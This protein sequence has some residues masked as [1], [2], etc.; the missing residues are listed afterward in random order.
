[1]LQTASRPVEL[2]LFDEDTWNI[3]QY[4]VYGL[5]FSGQYVRF[6]LTQNGSTL[7]QY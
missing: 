3:V 4:S 6:L 1:M 7:G 2:Y 5:F